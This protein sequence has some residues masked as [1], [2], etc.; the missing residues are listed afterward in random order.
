MSPDD[1]PPNIW[2]FVLLLSL[3]CILL[4]VSTRLPACNQSLLTHDCS[5]D[6]WQIHKQKAKILIFAKLYIFI[7]VY[8]DCEIT[9][10]TA[11]QLKEWMNELLF[12]LL[13]WLAKH[14]YVSA[15][16]VT[17]INNASIYQNSGHDE[18]TTKF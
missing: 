9:K 12:H 17:L 3:H 5:V 7:S 4:L 8:R 6:I 15:T 14:F 16:Y 13:Q 1:R 11:I 18:M 10:E 2:I